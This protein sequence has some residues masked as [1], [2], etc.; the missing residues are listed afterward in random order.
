MVTVAL[1]GVPTWYEAFFRMVTFTV[2]MRSLIRS[3]IG[4][5]Y[6]LALALPFGM[7]SFPASFL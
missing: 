1:A 7:T 4:W 2:S 6:Q 3:S 5:T